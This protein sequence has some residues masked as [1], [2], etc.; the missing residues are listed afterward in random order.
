ML[1]RRRWNARREGRV[2][3]RCV[4][5]CFRS[6]RG[7][8]PSADGGGRDRRVFLVAFGFLVLVVVQT[9]WLGQ[10]WAVEAVVVGFD[11]GWL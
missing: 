5:F 8:W 4:A 6:S 1:I 11:Q 3:V 10:L 2:V 9:R 7:P